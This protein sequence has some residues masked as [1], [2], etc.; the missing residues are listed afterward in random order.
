VN[1]D[2]SVRAGH[3]RQLTAGQVYKQ[4][5]KTP[6]LR[7]LRLKVVSFAGLHLYTEQ[8]CKIRIRNRPVDRKTGR[9]IRALG[10]EYQPEPLFG[11]DLVSASETE[12]L[13]GY[14]SSAQ[15]YEISVLMSVDLGTKTLIAAALAA[16][17]WGPDDKGR[18]IYYEEE[19][20]A[21]PMAGFDAGGA[22]PTP[23]PSGGWGG[24]PGT[25]FEDLL[26]NEEEGT[27]SGPA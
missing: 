6:V 14:N 4:S 10:A 25:G 7:T 27:G 17:D 26:R 1:I 15:P 12:T 16:I 2:P 22:D 21:T 23:P 24:G 20:P 5:A 11:E 19:I 18:Q 3:V 8:G 9:R 13:F